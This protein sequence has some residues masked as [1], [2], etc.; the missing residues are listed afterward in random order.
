MGSINRGF[1][2]VAPVAL[3]AVFVGCGG[4][5]TG[6]GTPG[7]AAGS[8]GL[9][10]SVPQG[11]AFDQLA[12]TVG[13][14]T[15]ELSQVQMVVSRIR[16]RLL[17]QTE[18]GCAGPNE[19]HP[20]TD[21]KAG[22]VLVD[23]PKDVL[24]ADTTY[25]P[26]GSYRFILINVFPPAGDDATVTAFRTANGWPA[27]ASMRVKGTYDGQAFDQY[28]N[29][30]GEVYNKLD[31]PFV[32]TGDSKGSFNVT[33]AVDPHGWFRTKEGALIDPRSLDELLP[34]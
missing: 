20:C 22:P 4:D 11:L 2:R 5:T 32:V 1:A 18:P 6:S 30:N 31:P 9:S 21:F 29:V 13:G 14:H 15:L 34:D 12:E 7:P 3:L 16:L 10:F 19:Q 26:A 33:I 8:V 27:T 28:L 25:V 23:L 24:N 17:E